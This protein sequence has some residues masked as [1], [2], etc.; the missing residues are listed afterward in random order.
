MALPFPR[1]P[2]YVAAFLIVT[3]VAFHPSYFS[4]LR[5][6]PLAHHFHG[7]TATAWIVLLITQS[8][9]AHAGKWGL[10]I[11]SGRASVLLVPLFT[12]AGLMVT[13]VTLLRD[14]AFNA[15]FGTPLAVADLAAS[16][17]FV[18]LYLLALRNRRDADRHARYML[19]TVFLLIGP[20]VA[21]LL[22]NFVPGF[23]IRSPDELF[24]FGWAVDASFALAVLFLLL[25]LVS[26]MRSGK[27][28]T[29]L[30]VSL[31]ATLG[32]YLGYVFIGP[33]PI[34]S[35][36]GAPAFAALPTPVII[37][38]GLALGVLAAWIGWRN[39]ASP[40]PINSEVAKE[41]LVAD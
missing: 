23:A 34:W 19:G 35:E 27:P 13:Q 33:L 14:S 15:M 41:G 21:R 31:S 28:R 9:S 16:L 3:L 22:A 2:Y 6:A 18:G 36:V 4:V 7:V 12:A 29:P 32:M 26:D 30:L 1:A 37:A 20:S 17:G 8:W 24:K 40:Q 39:P 10:H 5:E 11:W 38:A 25:L